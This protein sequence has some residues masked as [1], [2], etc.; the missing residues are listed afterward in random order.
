[1]ERTSI[2]PN[3]T[4]SPRLLARTV[5]VILAG[6]KGERLWPLTQH[7]SKPSVP[8]GGKYRIIDFTLSNCINSGFRR[9]YVLTQ[10][11]SQSLHEHLQHGWQFLSPQLGEFITAVPPQLLKQDR[12]YEG[13]A[14]AIYQNLVHLESQDPHFVVVLSGDHI[15]RMDYSSMM[16]FHLEHGADVTISAMPVPRQEATRF[17]VMGINEKRQITDWV[18]KPK[19]PPGMPENPELSLA[20]MGIY[21]FNADVLFRFLREDAASEGSHDF[22]RDVIPNMLSAGLNVLAFPFTDESK[23]EI[24]YWRDIG[25]LDS[26]YEA[27][28]DLIA[29]TP[30][31]NLYDRSWPVW[32]YQ[33]QRGPAKTV[34]N[35]LGFRQG[36]V[37]DSL[38]CDGAIVSGA[39][40]ARSILGPG[41]RIHSF[42][43]VTDCILMDGVDVGRHAR[44]RRA[45]VDKDVVI[46]PFTEIGY[47]LA[48]D[49]KRF[50]VSEGG[51]VAIPKG[52]VLPEIPAKKRT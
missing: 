2:A 38:I 50:T 44:I 1:M 14:D 49:A 37:V 19:S 6:G 17:G 21:L 20:N 3:V 35:E 8:F 9:I 13:T 33:V 12:W 27:T 31:F 43:Q 24:P 18:E 52:A 23:A 45:I 32:T 47:D 15:Y 25:T 39:S 5:T 30:K 28:M 46:P 41:V 48:E 11:K 36:L 29:V 51:I 4:L 34:F 7:R 16:R 22:G 42:S 40:V 10:Y 26:Y